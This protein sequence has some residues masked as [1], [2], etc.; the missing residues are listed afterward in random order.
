MVG[1][2]ADERAAGIAAVVSVLVYSF[3]I[4]VVEVFLSRIFGMV[5]NWLVN[6]C[7]RTCWCPG[8]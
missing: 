7:V 1:E 3:D 6:S 8:G 2:R 4:G 5:L